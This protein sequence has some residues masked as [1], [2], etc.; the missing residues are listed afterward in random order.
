MLCHVNRFSRIPPLLFFKGGKVV[1]RVVGA[2]SKSTISAKVE[3][4]L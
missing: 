1:D 4:L 2:V 3:A